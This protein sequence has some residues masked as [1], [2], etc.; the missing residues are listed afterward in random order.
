MTINSDWRCRRV[1]APLTPFSLILPHHSLIVCLGFFLD[2]LQMKK[3]RWHQVLGKSFTLY[4]DQ[5]L[6]KWL[7]QG[8]PMLVDPHL[9]Q[10]HA[11][12]QHAVC[13]LQ[14]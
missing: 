3:Q 11:G 8:S 14:H 13:Q 9:S 4:N 5:L 6:P 7:L 12:L 1:Q 10:Q 2:D